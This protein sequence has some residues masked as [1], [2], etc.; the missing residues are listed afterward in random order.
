MNTIFYTL[1][2]SLIDSLSTTFQIIIFVLLLTTVN[3]LRNALSYLAGLSGAYFLCGFAGY[4][5]IDELRILMNKLIPTQTMANP[6]YYESEFLTGIVN[7]G[8]RNLVLL[9][10]KKEA[11][12]AG[13]LLDYFKTEKYE[14]LVRFFYWPLYLRNVV[15]YFH[16]LFY[17]PGQVLNSCP[18]S[19]RCYRMDSVL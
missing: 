12:R 2:I 5:V 7:G 14:H 4:F 6:V 3:P 9:Q 16:S 15:P 8:D 19:S 18:S 10:E 11:L 17:R 13:D 1:S